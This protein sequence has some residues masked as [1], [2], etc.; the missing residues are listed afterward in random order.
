MSYLTGLECIRCGAAFGIEPRFDGCPECR[1]VAPANLTARYDFQAIRRTFRKDLLRHRPPSMWRYQELLPPDPREVSTLGEGMT[2]LVNCP[3]YG[4]KLG[5]PRLY[6]KDESRNPTGSFKDRLAAAALAMATRFSARTIG[7]SSTGNAGAAAAAYAARKGIPCVVLTAPGGPSAVA[8]QIQ[9]HGAMVLATARKPDR[10]KLLETAVREWGWYP[11]SPYFAPP[12]GSNPYGVEGYKTIAYEIS[13]QL[14][15]QVP[16]WC[17]L[18]VAYGDALFGM[19]K[20]FDELR[21][22]GFTDRC[23]RLVAAEMSGSLRA[24]LESGQDAVPEIPAPAPYVAGSISVNQ[25]TYQA[26]FAL[27]ASGGLAVAAENG[28]LLE[29]QRELAG[30]EGLYGEPSSLA[31]LAALRRLRAD[32]TIGVNDAVV[33]VNTATGLKDPQA[34]A[35][36]APAIPVI[37]DKVEALREKLSAVYGYAVEEAPAR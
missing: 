1:S 33:V 10:W 23:P 6:I 21:R 25:S 5:V 9:A 17:V 3:R 30:R 24:A 28:E 8:T 16:D 2:P 13:E 12:I 35:S 15:W 14:D 29:L 34:T 19:W 11:T 7:V 22:L 36:Q 37:G 18:A 26:L 4:S 20:G 32:G 31:A 27:R